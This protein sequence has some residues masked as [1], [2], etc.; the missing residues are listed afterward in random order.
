MGLFFMRKH[1][2]IS[3]ILMLSFGFQSAFSHIQSPFCPEWIT[4]YVHGTTTALGTKLLQK[5]Y[6]KMSF[7]APG[8]HHI[9]QLPDDALLRQDVDLMQQSDSYRFDKN[10][11]YTFGW[12]GK[13]SLKAR[14]Q[15][16]KDLYDQLVLLLTEYQKKYGKIPKVRILTFSHGGNVA[17][18]MVEHLPFFANQ[19]VHLELILVAVPVQKTTEYLIEHECIAK[20]YI[21]SSTRDLL[22]IVDT[23]RFEKKR[24]WPKRFFDTKKCN[25]FQVKVLINDRGLS[26]VDLMRSF[27]IHLPYVL[28]FAD[29][30]VGLMHVHDQILH[31]NIQDE[32]FNFYNGFNLWTSLHGKRKLIENT[33]CLL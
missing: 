10:H 14:A 19:N 1:S 30:Q 27:V 22:Q 33:L 2:K 8:L 6:K 13:L 31:C 23:Y 21:I 24:Y 28:Q 29:K 7:G 20:S 17:L 9:S 11:F 25:C 4:V 12:S 5:L 18:H 15:A 16:G 32:A 26:H 3:L